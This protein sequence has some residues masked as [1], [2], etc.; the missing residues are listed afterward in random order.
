MI[1]GS[2]GRGNYVPFALLQD[3]KLGNPGKAESGA[4]AGIGEV[5]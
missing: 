2:T 4:T 5:I 1:T 3:H